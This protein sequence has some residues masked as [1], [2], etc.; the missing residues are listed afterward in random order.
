MSLASVSATA[1]YEPEPS[2]EAMADLGGNSNWSPPDFWSRAT[3]FSMS[4]A[5]VSAAAASEPEPSGEAMAD[6][7][8]NS[9]WGSPDSGNRATACSMS[10]A[11]VSAA[12]AQPESI[13]EGMTDLGVGEV[14][15]T[16]AASTNG[17]WEIAAASTPDTEFPLPTTW[18]GMSHR[19]RKTWR[20][21]QNKATKATG[22]Q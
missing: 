6:L 12:A 11:S 22:S 8:G 15:S 19:Q 9:N 14:T 17:A 7:G 16:V 3:S 13:D 20:R 2:G 10:L 18:A 21:N 4:L 1:A 5:S